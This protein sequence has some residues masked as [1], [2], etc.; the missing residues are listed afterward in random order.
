MAYVHNMATN[1][2]TRERLYNMTAEYMRFMLRELYDSSIRNR[3]GSLVYPNAALDDELQ[4]LLETFDDE[5]LNKFHFANWRAYQDRGGR[6]YRKGRPQGAKNK[7]KSWQ[8]HGE[9]RANMPASPQQIEV[10]NDDADIMELINEI[11]HEHNKEQ[12]KNEQPLV[13]VNNVDLS[14]YVTH[15]ELK[16]AVKAIGD[17]LEP[18]YTRHDHAI[19]SLGNDQKATY[20]RLGQIEHDL[21]AIR[22]L[23]I[24]LANPELPKIEI[25]VQH[26]HFEK[27]LRTC[28]AKLPG[29]SRFNVWIYGPAGTGKSTAAVNVAKALNLDF[30]SDGKLVSEH[31]IKGYNDAHGRYITTEFR[32]A[33]EHGGIYLADEIDGSFPDALLAFNSALANGFMAF[34]DKLVERHPDFIFIG[35][36]NTTGTGGT[37]EYVGRMKQDAAFNDRFVYIDWPIDDQL[38]ASLC[39]GNTDWLNYVRRVRQN[40]AAQGIKGHLITP[41]A[42][43]YGAGLI[44]AG[45]SKEEAAEMALRKGL[46]D[47]QWRM[48]K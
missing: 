48:V 9:W 27:L 37:L 3:N 31:Q 29:N 45:F 17:A 7:R 2:Y 43:I 5:A 30:Y 16:I 35:A 18:I 6:V 44:A 22:P 8:K 13:P 47:A 36:A 23:V 28:N 42:T 39:L 15:P 33:Y 19:T 32:K 26:K 12:Q 4:G 10:K 1:S 24:Q 34:P 21:K 40:Y 14:N 25:G 41:R 20:A 11:G 46:T 38:E